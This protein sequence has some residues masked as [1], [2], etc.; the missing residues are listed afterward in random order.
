[1][2]KLSLL[3]SLLII[4]V[5]SNISYGQFLPKFGFKGGMSNSTLTT[6]LTNDSLELELEKIIS[7]RPGFTFGVF[8]DLYQTKHITLGTGLDFFQK[9]F[10]AAISEVTSTGT[11]TGYITYNQNY[12]IWNLYAKISP[13]LEQVNP[14]VIVAPRLD[15]FLGYKGY[16]SDFQ[17]VPNQEISDPLE[18]F[19]EY[20]KT[21]PSISFGA[22]VEINKIIP[23]SILVEFMYVPDIQNQYDDNGNKA[24]NTAFSISAGLKF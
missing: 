11:N 1:M 9:G 19:E 13:G 4:I 23:Y 8:A 7:Y 21:S 14:Y 3:V 20:K 17:T 24:K 10:K 12:L 15:F 18:L 2:K 5:S 16:T 6:D 22:G